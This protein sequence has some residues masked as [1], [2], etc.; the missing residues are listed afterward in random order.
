MAASFRACCNELSRNDATP[1]MTVMNAG[2]G[3]FTLPVIS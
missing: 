3:R 2:R 1:G